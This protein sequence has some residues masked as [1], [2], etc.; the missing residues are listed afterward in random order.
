MT[1]QPKTKI[2][3]MGG[4]FN[5][6]H[7]GHLLAAEAARENFALQKILFIPSG[8]P[9]H[10][11]E[12]EVVRAEDRYKMVEAAVASNPNFEALRIEID[13]KGRTYSVDTLKELKKLYG[14][15]TDFYFIIGADIINELVLWKDYLELFSLCGFIA[16]NRPGFDISGLSGEVSQLL[17]QNKLRIET[18]KI[19]ML[20]ISSSDIRERISEGRSIRYLT[21]TAVEDYIKNARLYLDAKGIK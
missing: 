1:Q 7:F 13:R 12:N 10:K 21:P 19:P 16:V 8:N 3:I 2:G 9:P 4:T 11:D 17:A 20:E 18:L 14:D 15:G 5:P 6:P